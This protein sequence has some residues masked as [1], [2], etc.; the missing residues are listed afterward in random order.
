MFI[1]INKLYIGL[2]VVL[3]IPSFV[4]AQEVDLAQS[5]E[6]SKM[7]LVADLNIF[8][9]KIVAQKENNIDISFALKN[10]TFVQPDIRYGVKLTE[11][12]DGIHNQLVD[13]KIYDDVLA[14][15]I[16]Q[17][18]DKKISYQA[19]SYL[20]GKYQLWVLA[21]NSSSL[22]LGLAAAGDI[23]LNG[24][25]QYLNIKPE[26]CYLMI[27]NEADE[28]KYAI[29]EGVA[30][31]IDENLLGYCKVENQTDLN[32]EFVPKINLF[33]RTT[34]GEEIVATQ[35]SLENIA[36][37]PKEEMDIKFAISKPVDG[38]PQAYDAK[39]ILDEENKKVMS[40]GVVFHYV[41]AGS[42]ATLQNVVLDKSQYEAGDKAK[43]NIFW[44][45]SADDFANSRLGKGTQLN[46][47]SLK[48][49]IKDQNGQDCVKEYL[50]G[51]SDPNSPEIVVELP[52]TKQC[53]KPK[54]ETTILSETNDLLAKK[55]DDFKI[56]KK[57]TPDPLITSPI[58]Y[59]LM[60]V[61]LL[62]ILIGFGLVVG[63]IIV[64]NIIKK[65]N[66]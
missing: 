49:M 40:N 59:W 15:D 16:N 51:I 30:I 33:Y 63:R 36:I 9:A 65:R 35:N 8:D 60:V 19:P 3:L 61:G 39:L 62:V 58:V 21:T 2:L 54:V 42:S 22:T 28:K 18:V 7:I 27:E 38:Q 17:S 37:G 64:K 56:E 10:K 13:Q 11:K 46:G 12:I 50:Q 20:K 52:I 32:L 26:T 5:E 48:L 25:N 66:V 47:L 1:K 24:T 53:I 43:I 44:A 4:M 41:L 34:A 14:L 6:S 31:K 55:I 45:D 29:D 57:Q 23:E